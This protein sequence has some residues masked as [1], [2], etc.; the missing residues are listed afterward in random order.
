MGTVCV[1]IGKD[2]FLVDEAA[3]KRL[4][5]DPVGLEV[6]DASQASNAEDQMKSLAAADA[7]FS[8]PPFLDPVK[9]TWWRN[10]K[11]LPGARAKSED[12]AADKTSA[13]VKA[14]LERFAA[15]IA[16]NPPPDN[17]TFILTAPTLLMTSV[18]AKRLKPVAEF[19]VF[20]EQKDRDRRASSLDRARE[21]AAE[22][23]FAFDPGAAEAFV[24]R[25]GDDTRS[26]LQEVRKLRDYLD[27]A[28]QTAT[29]A[30]VAAISSPGV[31]NESPA[32]DV[33]DALGA[34]DVAALVAALRRFEGENGFAVFMTTIAEKYVRQLLEIKA[35]QEAGRTDDCAGAFNPFVFRKLCG[36][37]RNWT[38]A[39]LRRARE[40]LMLLRE[41]VVSSNGA[42]DTLVFTELIRICRRPVRRERG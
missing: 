36:F 12:G 1:I 6:I 38:L 4:G 37:A 15:K 7:S 28:A 19:V 8:T 14:A 21:F 16:A 40:R 11:F 24:A 34:R 10:V 9:T 18:F 32:W 23:G 3:K 25:V 29:A 42:A 2:D 31:G 30:D 39:E 5:T 26:L 17:Q 13:E 41:K 22:A 20:A 35:A 27:P 33:T